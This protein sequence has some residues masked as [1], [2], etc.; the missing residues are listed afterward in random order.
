M[1]CAE[2]FFSLRE[3]RNC[4]IPFSM[5]G[6]LIATLPYYAASSAD[7]GRDTP[8]SND[9]ARDAYKPGSWRCQRARGSSAPCAGRR[10][11]PPCGWRN[12][13][14]ACAGWHAGLQPARMPTPFAIPAG[15]L[16]YG[17]GGRG[18]KA[19]KAFRRKELPFPT[20]DKSVLPSAHFGQA[21][22]YALYHPCR[23]LSCS[24]DRVWRL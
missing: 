9:Q 23:A 4:A 1:V 10:R 3:R 7:G 13:G 14:A 17:S 21:A 24:R 16:V 12:C 6:V 18:I 11:S 2:E 15:G 20:L 5:V 19:A 8:F 22:R